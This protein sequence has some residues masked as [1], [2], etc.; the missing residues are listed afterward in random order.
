ML[1]DPD[2]TEE[3]ILFNSEFERFEEFPEIG[4]W[5]AESQVEL[6]I[7]WIKEYSNQGILAG[8]NSKSQGWVE[9]R[10]WDSESEVAK[11]D[12]DL[13]SLSPGLKICKAGCKHQHQYH[14]GNSTLPGLKW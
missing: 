13:E 8:P 1:G 11:V 7:P 10:F 12:Y 4:K 3:R 9:W 2:T 14:D 6:S 5:E